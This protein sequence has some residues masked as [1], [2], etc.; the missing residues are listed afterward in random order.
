MPDNSVT[1]PS[2]LMTTAATLFGDRFLPLSCVAWEQSLTLLAL[3]LVYCKPL[4]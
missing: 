3:L 2:L 1:L 4:R